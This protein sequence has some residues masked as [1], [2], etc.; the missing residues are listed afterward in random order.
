[1]FLILETRT[2]KKSGGPFGSETVVDFRPRFFPTVGGRIRNPGSLAISGR[3]SPYD[4][5]KRLRMIRLVAAISFTRSPRSRAGGR[6]IGPGVLFSSMYRNGLF[7]PVT[8]LLRNVWSRPWHLPHASSLSA[9]STPWREQGKI[10]KRYSN[11]TINQSINRLIYRRK[12]LER[13]NLASSWTKSG[14]QRRHAGWAGR[15]NAAE[16]IYFF[17]FSS[18]PM[19]A[20]RLGTNGVT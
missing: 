2:T 5:V 10:R 16:Q 20:E 14:W 13:K 18:S 6:L 19:R 7:S 12:S 3:S 17:L 4:L 11:N 8:R 1:M 15:A 9:G